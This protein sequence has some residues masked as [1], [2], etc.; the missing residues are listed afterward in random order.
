M[1]T[2]YKKGCKKLN[3]EVFMEHR[4]LYN[5]ALVLL[6]IVTFVAIVLQFFVLEKTLLLHPGNTDN[7]SVISDQSMGGGSVA[8]L[9][10]KDGNWLMECNVIITDY[11]WPFCEISISFFDQQ[12]NQAG[13]GIDLSSF[14]TV[15]LKARY[16]NKGHDS[17]RFQLRNFSPDYGSVGN[18]NTWKYVGIEYWPE[19]ATGANEI[20]MESLQV[21][22][23]WIVEQ[24]LPIKY[25]VP[26]FDNVMMLELA[27]G[28][29]IQPGQY[30]I[31]VE[32]IKFT[33]K[34]FTN[35]QVLF[36]LIFLWVS[37]AI[38]FLFFSLK[39][40]RKRL[41]ETEKKAEDLRQLN[42]LLNVKTKELKDKAERDPLT[43]ALNRAGIQKIFTKELEVLSLIFID[44]DH[45]KPINDNYGHATG[46][47]ILKEFSKTISK[48]CRF[49]DFLARWGGE[50]FL[51]VCPNTSLSDAYDLAKALR[52]I[53]SKKIW[54]NN[55][56]LT[57]SFGVAQ[58]GNETPRA[59]I[60]RADKA[61]YDAKVRGR[62]QV[63]LS[64]FKGS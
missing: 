18:Q 50:E 4:K 13:Q 41:N 29:N 52:K 40:S 46:D 63:V 36:F 64:E 12:Q 9:T 30:F 23:W 48:N 43:G 1:L 60:E 59:F 2:I 15:Y 62:D 22:T 38:C 42:Q 57:A 28:N 6:L 39:W 32:Y 11:N 20:P 55:I 3:T 26:E 47:D 34:Y 7:P 10:E 37:S 21:A 8:T 33:G 35:N 49:T 31:E 27:T 24:R 61:L 44:I 56:R 54:V 51:L 53:V 16:L 25:A 14:S 58:R 17:L 19:N 45:F 5:L